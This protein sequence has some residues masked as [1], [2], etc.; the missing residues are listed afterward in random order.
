MK[1]IAILADSG[2]QLPI[3]TLENQGIYIVPLTITMNNKAYLDF[4][5]ISALDVFERMN[6]TGEIIKTSQPSTGVIQAAVKRIMV[7]GYD[8]II[9]ISIAT[10]LSSTLSGMKL[11]CDMAQMPV[12]LIDTKG[13]ANNHRY[14]IKVAKKLIDNQKDVTEIENV[15][16]S[17]I[18]QSATLI[19]TPNLTHLKKGGR[20]TPAVA[21]LGGMMKIKPI[22]QIQGEKLDTFSKSRTLSK[23]TKIMIE[24]IQKDIEERLDPI[25]KGKN[26]HICIAYTYDQQPAL[27]LKEE[28]QQ[29]YPNSN[30]ICDPLSLSVSCHIG[31]HALAIA[32]C[33][34]I[35]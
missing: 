18:E 19:M 25:E 8:H 1:K 17:L 26:V 21:I 12:T 9:A 23:A 28:L 32:A 29:L 14:L 27:E 16:T 11:A 35:I 34:K 2:C 30:I 20:I 22:L 24:A 31:P 7:N 15:L 13:T 5:E 10:G 3:G 6:E 4:E 33:K